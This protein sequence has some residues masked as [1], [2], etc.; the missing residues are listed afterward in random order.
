MLV[1]L[2]GL[3][4]S[5]GS[6]C[7][8]DR[9]ITLRP[10]ASEAPRIDRAQPVRVLPF[11]DRRGA[12][13]EGG[14]ETV[15]GLYGLRGWPAAVR[16]SEPYTVTLQRALVNALTARGIPATSADEAD[17][18]YAVSGVIVDF[19][20][21]ANWGVY[22]GLR[23]YV[24]LSGPDGKMIADKTISRERWEWGAETYPGIELALT[25]VIADWVDEVSLDPD[26]TTPLVTQ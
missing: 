4:A 20:G 10:Q 19:Y 13:A 24:R 14:T 5:L 15:G 23:A 9:V 3:T 7:L 22:A 26:L 25:K 17:Q 11:I 16:L 12:I 8:S 2:L 18:S 6:G 1:L 21:S